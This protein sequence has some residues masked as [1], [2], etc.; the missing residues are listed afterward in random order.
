MVRTKLAELSG[1]EQ[2]SWEHSSLVGDFYFKVVEY[3]TNKAIDQKEIFE[4]IDNKSKLYSGQT[5][6]DIY[7]QECLPII[8]AYK[9]YGLP[10]IELMRVYS[11][12]SYDRIRQKFSDNDID[13][14]NISF[15]SSWGF[16]YHN[17]RWYYKDEY[18]VMGD[19][20]PLEA[21]RMEKAPID[22]KEINVCFKIVGSK[23]D[24]KVYFEIETNLPDETILIFTLSSRNNSY[25]A[26]S[27]NSVNNSFAK[28]DGFTLKGDE[29]VEGL[30][31]LS[32]SS[33]IHNVQPEKVKE[34]LDND[35]RNLIGKYVE[36]SPFGGKIVRCNMTVI[37]KKNE[38]LVYEG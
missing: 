32:I 16:K 26:Q 8:D 28:T 24:G 20:L 30:Y 7:D 36:H 11:R 17:Y 33:P 14:L 6:L 25:M 2:I 27:K 10:I 23:A 19:P 35:N 5:H 22:N 29:I 12:E 37:I 21:N 15:I 31:R 13:E 34:R 1:N 3:P 38:V 4:F 18:V 9:R